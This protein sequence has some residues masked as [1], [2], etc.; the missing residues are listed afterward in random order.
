ME[1]PEQDMEGCEIA[2]SLQDERATNVDKD[3]VSISM[4]LE[5]CS[6]ENVSDKITNEYPSWMIHLTLMV[7]TLNIQCLVLKGLCI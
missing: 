4:N 6:E 1:Y 2:R 7:I 3:S 5:V